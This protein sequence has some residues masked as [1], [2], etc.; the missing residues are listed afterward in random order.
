MSDNEQE[1]DELERRLAEQDLFRQVVVDKNERLEELEAE[2]KYLRQTLR[3]VLTAPRP[4]YA[5]ARAR[6]PSV[7]RRWEA[8]A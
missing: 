8:A 1:R 5:P 7:P 4:A 6:V 2:V 3:D